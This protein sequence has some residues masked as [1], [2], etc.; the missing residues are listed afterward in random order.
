MSGSDMKWTQAQKNLEQLWAAASAARQNQQQQWA[1]A[2]VPQDSQQQAPPG[3]VSRADYAKLEQKVVMVEQK[4]RQQELVTNELVQRLTSVLSGAV[5]ANGG[6]YQAKG[7]AR[8]RTPRRQKPP[9]PAVD[10]STVPSVEVFAVQNDLD[11]RCTEN[12]MSQPVEV[13]NFVMSQGPASGTNPSAMIVG[14]IAKCS[15]EFDI[16]ASMSEEN[17]GAICSKLEEF[18]AAHLL[19]DTIANAL[20]SAPQACQ[21]AVMSL[22]QA[23]GRNPSAM[24]A[25]RMGKWHKGQL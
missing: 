4:L 25:A 19:D 7:Y 21:V 9:L 1:A 18:I 13:Q 11:E 5:D 2:Y 24:I 22:G 16:S 6:G 12:L 14:R 20:R 17:I 15:R 23:N 3:F 10:P 8:E